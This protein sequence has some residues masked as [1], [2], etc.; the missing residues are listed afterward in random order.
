VV[1]LL[2]CPSVTSASQPMSD[3]VSLGSRSPRSPVS[4][5]SSWRWNSQYPFVNLKITSKSNVR[6]DQSHAGVKA[7]FSTHPHEPIARL[8]PWRTLDSIF[9]FLVCSFGAVLQCC[10]AT[11]SISSHNS[12]K[13]VSGCM[14]WRKR[15]IYFLPMMQ[16]HIGTIPCLQKTCLWPSMLG[17]NMGA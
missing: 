17:T 14:V 10:I 12:A 8:H 11:A 5:I 13:A 7:P 2:A 16:S 15:R 1:R 9:I 3:H 6:I 4:R